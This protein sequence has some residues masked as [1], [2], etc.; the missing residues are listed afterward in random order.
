MYDGTNRIS[1]YGECEWEQ[2]P[3]GRSEQCAPLSPTSTE[4]AQEPRLDLVLLWPTTRVVLR[5]GPR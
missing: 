2:V 3:V 1:Y 5:N 4:M